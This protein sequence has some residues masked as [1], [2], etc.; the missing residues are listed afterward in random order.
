MWNNIKSTFQKFWSIRILMRLKIQSFF[1]KDV[2]IIRKLSNETLIIE[3]WSIVAENVEF[4][5]G[6]EST[7]TA[8]FGKIGQKRLWFQNQTEKKMSN[9][10]WNCTVF[11]WNF[12]GRSL[13]CRDGDM[14]T[15]KSRWNKTFRFFCNLRVFLFRFGKQYLHFSINL[16]C[17]ITMKTFERDMCRKDQVRD[18]WK[19]WVWVRRWKTYPKRIQEFSENQDS[20]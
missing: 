9:H 12:D 6:K 4:D 15:W 7:S 1:L 18:Y 11:D 19:T 17:T 8:A 5:Y 20:V 3:L 14:W 10:L 2:F 16:V 13:T